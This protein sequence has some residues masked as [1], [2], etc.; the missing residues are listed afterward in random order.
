MRIDAYFWLWLD[1]S[2]SSAM[3][4]NN[5]WNVKNSMMKCYFSSIRWES[6]PIFNF[7]SI[8]PCFQQWLPIITETSKIQWRSVIPTVLDENRCSNI[9][10]TLQERCCN[11]P[12]SASLQL[13]ATLQQ[14]RCSNIAGT[15][16]MLQQPCG[17]VDNVAATLPECC[18]NIANVLGILKKKMIKK[19][20]FMMK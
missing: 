20:Y 8:P 1:Y 15:L 14:Q 19:Y 17:N 7:I 11:I 18:G 16:P 5:H 3:V 2:M 9:A 13:A 4:T 6:M 12:M 10:R